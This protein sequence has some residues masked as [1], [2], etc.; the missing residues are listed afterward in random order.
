MITRDILVVDDDIAYL[1]LFSLFLKSEGFDVAA[2]Q[3]GIKALGTM[4]NCNFRIVITDFN[5]PEMNGL[6][7][8]IKVRE[9]HP[10]T[11]VVLVT[12]DDLPELLKVAVDTGIIEIF[13]KPVDLKKLVKTV[14]TVI[15]GIPNIRLGK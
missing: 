14:L 4:E 9:R 3:D 1:Y 6:D 7:L 5:M 10:E 11:R 8:A 13:S 12:A 2:A 15:T